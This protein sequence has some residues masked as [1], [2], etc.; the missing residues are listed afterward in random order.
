M[1]VSLGRWTS[2]SG[3]REQGL[4]CEARGPVNSVWKAQGTL[5]HLLTHGGQTESVR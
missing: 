1:E 5:E 4:S 3:V 2:K